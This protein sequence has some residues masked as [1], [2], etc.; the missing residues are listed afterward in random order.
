MQNFVQLNVKQ[1]CDSSSRMHN[2][3]RPLVGYS[4]FSIHVI[5]N[6]HTSLLPSLQNNNPFSID[7]SSSYGL[8][9]PPLGE[10]W[11]CMQS[12]VIRRGFTVMMKWQRT[13]ILSLFVLPFSF[14]FFSSLPS[15]SLFNSTSLSLFHSVEPVASEIYEKYIF[16]CNHVWYT[17][18]SVVTDQTRVK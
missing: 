15:F 17:I 16:I 10:R 18:Y 4:S 13:L 12:A 6:T 2:K 7:F 1:N 8:E 5:A 14:S 3:F 11:E 9:V